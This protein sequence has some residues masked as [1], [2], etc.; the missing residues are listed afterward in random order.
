[1]KYDR[2]YCYNTDLEMNVIYSKKKKRKKKIPYHVA[3]FYINNCEYINSFVSKERIFASRVD[4][5]E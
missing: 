1:M 2:D 3:L 4:K 5:F